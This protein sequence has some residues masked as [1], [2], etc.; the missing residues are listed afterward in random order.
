MSLGFS[1]LIKTL[2][3]WNAV[4]YFYVSVFCVSDKLGEWEF[5]G[6]NRLWFGPIKAL[7]HTK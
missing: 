6:L 5:I 4:R 2:D 7:F 1:R 3:S